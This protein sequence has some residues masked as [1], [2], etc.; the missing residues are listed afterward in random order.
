MTSLVLNTADEHTHNHT[1]AP[2]LVKPCGVLSQ[3]SGTKPAINQSMSFTYKLPYLVTSFPGAL[4]N[5]P[6]SMQM[7]HGTKT[8]HH[9]NFKT[10]NF[11]NSSPQTGSSKSYSLLLSTQVQILPY[12]FSCTQTYLFHHL[13]K[14]TMFCTVL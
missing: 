4:I 9:P 7:D 5:D 8:N 14:E 13:Y 2:P 1:V 10:L 6:I 3:F 11:L 12:L